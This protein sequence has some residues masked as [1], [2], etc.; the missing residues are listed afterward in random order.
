[1]PLLFDIL[2][3]P[4][5][6]RYLRRIQRPSDLQAGSYVPGMFEATLEAGD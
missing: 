4:K 3:F 5:S 6:Q 1:M 2:N